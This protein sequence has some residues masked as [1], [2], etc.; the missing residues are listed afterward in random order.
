MQYYKNI[1]EIYTEKE[2]LSRLIDSILNVITIDAVFLSKEQREG[3]LTY[4]ILTFIADVDNDP[5]P[6]EVLSWLAKQG[7]SHPNLRIRI[8]TEEQSE[9]ALSRG[10]LYFLEHC[11]LGHTVFVRSEGG[12]LLDYP[13]M[14][15]G[16]ILKRA[17]RYRASEMEKVGTFAHTADILIREGNHA[18][19]TFNM[20]QAFEL[21]FRF[22]ERMCM[23]K[24]RVTHSIISHINY[25]QR[26]FPTLRPFPKTMDMENNELLLILEHSYSVARYGNEFEIDRAQIIS[27]QRELRIFIRSMEAIFNRHYENCRIRIEGDETGLPQK[28]QNDKC[29]QGNLI[30]ASIRQRLRE[31]EIEHLRFIEKVQ[32]LKDLQ[33]NG[34]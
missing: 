34:Q 3:N 10:S 5:I 11:C 9:M 30:E 17:I 29:S 6:H 25:C 1:P 18:I 23:G 20:H 32:E 19:A 8:Y 12:N 33:T 7:K 28:K 31:I 26:Y 16:N 24:A 15:L 14:N 22:L 13:E 21:G 4:H 27:I 2:E